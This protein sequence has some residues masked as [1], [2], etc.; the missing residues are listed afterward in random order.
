MARFPFIGPAYTLASVAAD[1]QQLMNW[2]L[3]AD[4][5]KGGR[6]PVYLKRTPGITQFWNLTSLATPI[7]GLWAGENRM[8]CVAGAFFCEL[9]SDGTYNVR[10]NVGTDGLPVSILANGDQVLIVSAG[11]VYCDYG[12]GPVQISFNAGSGTVNT[13]GTAVTWESG[14]Q[15]FN[16]AAN[17]LITIN[18]VV[19]QIETV[20]DDTDIVLTGSAGVQSG[21]PWDG[22]G[23][24]GV[25]NIEAIG[26]GTWIINLV[27]GD[28]FPSN[29]TTIQLG[30]SLSTNPV[31]YLSPVQL[32]TNTFAIGNDVQYGCNTPISAFQGTYIDSYFIVAQPNSKSFY[33]SANFDGT[34]WDAADTAQKEGYP[35]NIAAIKAD[36]E[37]LWLL[38]DEC[39][40]EVWLDTGAALFPFQRSAAQ[41]IHWG[42]FASWSCTRFG[43][44]IAWVGGDEERGGPF[45]FYA[46]GSGPNRIST[47]AIEQAW[48]QYSVVYDAVAYSTVEDGHEILI[49]NFPTA[50]AT[51]C[52]DRTATAALGVPCWHQRSTYNPTTMNLDRQR[53]AFHAAVVM[54]A[55]GSQ[56]TPLPFTSY[57][58]DW[59]NGLIYAS[60]ASMT[61]DNGVPIHR[62]RTSQH[63]AGVDN[64]RTFFERF[65][66]LID[67]GPA[68]GSPPAPVPVNPVLS[69]SVDGGHTFIN[70]QSRTTSPG[71]T[72]PYLSRFLWWRQGAS[73]DRVFMLSMTD[74]S[75]FAVIDAY[76]ESSQG[77]N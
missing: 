17:D 46:E 41:S 47:H 7:R 32:S 8:F 48:A 62:I 34:T 76:F 59:Q 21:V 44:G 51:W 28:P 73:R 67:L 70:P 56:A 77:T 74:A 18:G 49:V 24:N 25:V 69:Y 40:G 37:Q 43:N 63:G 68:V 50:N 58:G 29:I 33:I 16:L 27:S 36:H 45:A 13:N 57:Q 60:S 72:N 6:S 5:T 55:H 61:T 4:E 64:L 12:I 35:D 42:C 52:Y 38:G 1:N 65:E 30:T 75:Q 31:T 53:G 39:S 15:F 3:E 20:T 23:N 14:S 10:G 22:F 9:F 19:Y 71:L 11:Y 26:S 2:Y 54:Q 66:L